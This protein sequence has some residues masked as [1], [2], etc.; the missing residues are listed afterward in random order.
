LPIRWR[1]ADAPPIPLR[2]RRGTGVVA[3]AAVE[4]VGVD[5]GLDPSGRGASEGDQ[6]R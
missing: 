1:A 3:E 4:D 5:E 6:K 2:L